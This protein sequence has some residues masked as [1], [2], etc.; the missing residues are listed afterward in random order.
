MCNTTASWWLVLLATLFTP[1]F[2]SATEQS[3]LPII[4]A[5]DNRI[6]AG[7]LKDGVLS[8]PLELRQARWYAEAP[9]GVYEDAYAFAEEGRPAQS[10]GPLLRVPKGTRVRV[11]L[12]NL[13]PVAAK[14]Y[15]L[16]AHPGDPGEFIQLRSGEE[17]QVQF[18]AWRTWYLYVLGNHLRRSP[19]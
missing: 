17:R 6:P 11:K 5:N 16:H 1:L 14:V 2:S 15:G 3:P 9:D 7:S 13:L 19:R 10:P 18:E 12:H 8:L 4:V